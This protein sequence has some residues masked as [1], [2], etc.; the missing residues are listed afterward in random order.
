MSPL[1]LLLP[2][3]L[4]LFLVFYIYGI[5]GC[6]CFG[7]NDPWHFGRLEDGLNALFRMAT[8][9]DWTNI[10]CKFLCPPIFENFDPPK[11]GEFTK[12]DLL[13][14]YCFPQIV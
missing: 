2:I 14:T 5:L 7:E 10:M 1:L 12:S 9:E 3:M 13:L 6:V 11:V 8:L 4:L